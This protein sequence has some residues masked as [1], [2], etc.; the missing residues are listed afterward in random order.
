MYDLQGI[1]EIIERVLSVKHRL[2]Y[3]R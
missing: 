2:P 1:G 3:L